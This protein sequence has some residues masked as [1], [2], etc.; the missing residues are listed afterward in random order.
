MASAANEVTETA[1]LVAIRSFGAG[2][3]AGTRGQRLDFHKQLVGRGDKLAVPLLLGLSNLL[4]AGRAPAE[5]RTFI[6]LAK[7]TAIYRKAKDGSDDARPAC[8]GEATR[9][10]IGN[11]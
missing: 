9:H 3:S 1:L 7:G 5:L 11:A 6:G 4:A 10:I 8:S 2:V